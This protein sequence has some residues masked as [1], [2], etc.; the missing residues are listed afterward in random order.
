[1]IVTCPFALGL[2]DVFILL[3]TGG[4]AA[5]VHKSEREREGKITRNRVIGKETKSED[6]KGYR[7]QWDLVK[8]E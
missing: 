8:R 1:M 6:G 2:E 3:S 7:T 4:G 5:E